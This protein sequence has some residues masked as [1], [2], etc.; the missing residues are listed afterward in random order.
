ME[1]FANAIALV[2]V[3]ITLLGALVARLAGG[4]LQTGGT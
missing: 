2:L 4:K 3:A 1:Q